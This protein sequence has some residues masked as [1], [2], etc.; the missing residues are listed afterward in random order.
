MIQSTSKLRKTRRA[1]SE[2]VGFVIIILLVMI[3]GVIFLGI[4]LKPKPHSI[5]VDA[6]ISNFLITSAKYTS[7]C[8]KDYEPNYRTL[9][10]L[11]ADCYQNIACLDGTSSCNLLNQ[12]YSEMLKS[13]RP[14]GRV[15]SYSKLS[16][17]YLENASAP[18]ERGTKFGSE[19]IF[20][21]SSTCVSKRYG[22]NYISL[23]QGSAVEQLEVCLV[24]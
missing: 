10:D 12:T 23:S 7:S 8:A 15:L 18:V 1:Q 22:R 17:Y 14:S 2:T 6:E 5:A 19:I 11:V 3:I 13:Y 24:S 21:N 20:G 9:G 16:F 4:S